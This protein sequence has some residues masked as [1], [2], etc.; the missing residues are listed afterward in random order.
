MITIILAGG[1]DKMKYPKVCIKYKD[2][3]MI[4]R[5]VNNAILLKS[6]MIIIIVNPT[7]HEKIKNIINLYINQNIFYVVQKESLGTCDA[8]KSC[9]PYLEEIDPF[10]KIL[11]L[12][13]DMPLLSFYTLNTFIKWDNSNDSRIL[14]C[15]IDNPSG[16]GR[17]I[18][19]K[20][21]NFIEIKEDIECNKEE[22]MIR[23]VNAGIYL[24]TNY[25][26]QENIESVGNNNAK[27][28][29]YITDLINYIKP[30]IY[31]LESKF[32]KELINITNIEMLKKLAR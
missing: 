8:L 3:P 32:Q 10:T 18:R 30:K 20:K 21:Y 24:L 29:Y 19:D 15:K 16:Y 12:N 9:I 31:M 11:I 26:I 17:I 28:E 13:A 22:K 4:V 6:E 5:A 7:T 14:S 2:M 23:Y 27:K 1:I 25:Q